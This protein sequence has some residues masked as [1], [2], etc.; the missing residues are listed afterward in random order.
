MELTYTK[1]YK[2]LDDKDIKFLKDLLGE[3]RV[4]TGKD[5]NDDFRDRKSVV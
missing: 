2:K 4:F 3:D 5:I 1:Q